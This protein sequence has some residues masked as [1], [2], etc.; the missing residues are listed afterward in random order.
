MPRPYLCPGDIDGNRVLDTADVSLMLLDFGPCAGCLSDLDG[1]GS[2][3]IADL[4]LLLLDFG[5]CPD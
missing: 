2:T 5:V 4:S 1:N 3:D